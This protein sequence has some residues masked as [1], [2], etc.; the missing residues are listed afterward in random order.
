M[1]S[2]QATQS[3]GFRTAADPDI[4]RTMKRKVYDGGAN[5]KWAA[6]TDLSRYAGNYVA[7]SGCRV[8]A[9]GKNAKTVLKRARR[10]C[11]R[12]EILLDKPFGN[13]LVIV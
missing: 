1:N 7:I 13:E 3:P 6:R 8:V 2:K 9:W 4:L 5:F 12:G 10:R 11:P